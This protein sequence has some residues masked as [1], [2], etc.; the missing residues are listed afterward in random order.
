[1]VRKI[2]A[3]SGSAI[4]NAARLTRSVNFADSAARY[5]A[6]GQ[7][8]PSGQPGGNISDQQADGSAGGEKRASRKEGKDRPRRE[9]GSVQET[10]AGGTGL[11][12]ADPF[13]A[14]EGSQSMTYYPRLAPDG[15]ARLDGLARLTGMRAAYIRKALARRVRAR[16]MHLRDTG[17]WGD[18]SKDIQRYLEDAKGAGAPFPRGMIRLTGEQQ[19]ALRQ[20]VDDPLGVFSTPQVLSAYAKAILALELTRLTEQLSPS[21]PGETTSTDSATPEK[22]PDRA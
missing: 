12:A 13:G 10:P 14:P 20:S 8:D 1:M 2:P 17:T 16:L 5:M 6:A 22:D 15:Q 18:H 7:G 11:R 9:S 21:Q 4:S 19:V 3:R